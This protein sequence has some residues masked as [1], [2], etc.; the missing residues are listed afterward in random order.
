LATALN[1]N[2]HHHP[3]SLWQTAGRELATQQEAPRIPN[4]NPGKKTFKSKTNGDE[5]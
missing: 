1:G 4:I 2:S 3:Q 5:F